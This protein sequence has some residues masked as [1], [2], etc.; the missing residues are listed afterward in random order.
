[1]ATLRQQK[2][3]NAIVGNGG[4]ISKGM[5]EAGYAPTTANKTE[6]LVNSKAWPELM[7]KYLPNDLIAKK[8]KA[9]FNQ[10][11]LDYF[12]FPKA[13]EDEEITEHVTAAGLKVIVIR[14]TEKGKMAFYSNDDPQAI[15]KATDMAY[16]LKGSYAPEKTL[17]LNVEVT[18]DEEDLSL[19]K[20]LL[21]QR[22]NKGN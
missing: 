13:M 15:A 2:A 22:T 10:K 11:Q 3:I 17:N 7:E 9:L 21:E 16:K 4:N 20:Q 8:H 19:A 14:Q 18:V 6:K 12:V 1:M 5:L